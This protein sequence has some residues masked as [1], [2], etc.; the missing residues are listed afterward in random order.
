MGARPIV[1]LFTIP[2][3]RRYEKLVKRPPIVKN[4][5]QL[6]TNNE[7]AKDGGEFQVANA[8]VA[9]DFRLSPHRLAIA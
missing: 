4:Q 8:E 3:L 2:F 1:P 7:F 6:S 5:L 9:A